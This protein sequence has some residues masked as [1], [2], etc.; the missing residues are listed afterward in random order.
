MAVDKTFKLIG[1]HG[2]GER[3]KDDYY[4]TDPKALEALLGGLGRLHVRH[5]RSSPSAP[6]TWVRM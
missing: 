4:A 5:Q 3:Q 6:R 1:A 2:T